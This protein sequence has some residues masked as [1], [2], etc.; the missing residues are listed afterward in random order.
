[1]EDKPHQGHTL[2]TYVLWKY[3]TTTKVRT[4]CSPFQIVYGKE[5]IFPTKHK[6]L[7]YG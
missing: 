1:M 3:H 6:F 5:D 7:L 4:C 2:L